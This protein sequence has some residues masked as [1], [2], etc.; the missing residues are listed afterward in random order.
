MKNYVNNWAIM[1]MIK[2]NL[3]NKHATGSQAKCMA[4]NKQK[5]C[6]DNK[7]SSSDELDIYGG[8]A[9]EN[10][11]N[12]HKGKETDSDEDMDNQ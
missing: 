8:E 3:K 10:G 9:K 12:C 5:N 2:T 6:N 4:L 7:E 11:K 1:E